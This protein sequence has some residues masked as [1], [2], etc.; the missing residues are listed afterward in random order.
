MFLIASWHVFL[1]VGLVEMMSILRHDVDCWS[2]GAC[3]GVCSD[4][5]LYYQDS[6]L[7]SDEYFHGGELPGVIWIFYANIGESH[8]SFS[9]VR[10]L[11]L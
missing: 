5:G 2:K 7:M 3:F 9:L 10:R 8:S 6:I 4:L 1:Y 11:H